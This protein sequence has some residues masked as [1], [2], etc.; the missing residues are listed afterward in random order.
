[1]KPN[2]QIRDEASAWFVEFSEG[3]VSLEQRQ[4]FSQW[5]RASPEHVRAYLKIAA[6]FEDL[7]ALEKSRTVT[8]E[9][10]VRQALADGNVVTLDDRLARPAARGSS[11]S[12][13]KL[14]PRL[15]AAAATLAAV[16]I[17]AGAWQLTQ[18]GVYSTGIGEQR[19]V[20]LADGS[21][22][23][24][25]AD[26]RIRVY[27]RDRE[28]DVELLE[29]QALFHVAKDPGRPFIVRSD[30][31]S[32]RAV[33]TQ[34]DV[35]RETSDTVVT[36]LEGRVA[37]VRTDGLAVTTGSADR[38]A[39]PTPLPQAGTADPGLPPDPNSTDS[40]VTLDSR[41]PA[42][43]GVSADVGVST[44]TGLPTPDR[45][46]YLSAGEQVVLTAQA[47][48]KPAHPDV[49][50]ATAWRERKLIFSSSPLADVA[51]EYNRYHEKRLRVADPALKDFR[52]SGVF[53]AADTTSLITFLRAQ[54]NIL[55]EEHE[56]EIVLKSK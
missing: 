13:T 25:N 53:S 10:L 32:V 20:N 41:F 14:R 7:G 42:G 1:M 33:G 35:N 37:I 56:S 19:L 51:G 54:S 5:L 4:E 29:G 18:R 17:A 12:A 47:A 3:D 39:M 31:T 9:A 8:A 22:I 11:G 23:E 52:I 28:R 27:L 26:S 16:A 49:T 6:T 15:F 21:T 40:A 43:S 44:I 24:L 55:V 34:F 46:L 45:P 30:S 36:V 2:T 50:A 38:K 48:S